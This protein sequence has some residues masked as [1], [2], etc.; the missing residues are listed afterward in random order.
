MPSIFWISHTQ[1][2]SPYPWASF[3]PL[4][5]LHLLSVFLC[6][7]ISHSVWKV[8]QN[9]IMLIKTAIDLLFMVDLQAT[10]KG[11][12]KK[13]INDER[14]LSIWLNIYWLDVI[15][16]LCH[17]SAWLTV[18]AALLA[19]YLWAPVLG[20]NSQK[21]LRFCWVAI[22]LFTSS[23]LP[24]SSWFYLLPIVYGLPLSQVLAIQRG[25]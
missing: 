9:L 16:P 15:S 12:K 8:S 6:D 2:L 4:L 23:P 3:L 19:H 20:N 17:L 13:L 5:V 21:Y 10:S 22:F 14:S 11:R 25:F 18:F 24:S 7:P 1:Q